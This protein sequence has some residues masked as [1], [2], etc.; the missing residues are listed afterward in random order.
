[1]DDESVTPTPV[2]GDPVAAAT[3]SPR[4]VASD[5]ALTGSTLVVRKTPRHV[6]VLATVRMRFAHIK[7]SRSA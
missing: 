5:W 7:A 1:L 6:T 4:R 3:T 2:S